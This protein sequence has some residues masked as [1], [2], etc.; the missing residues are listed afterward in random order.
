VQLLGQ[1][2]EMA[3]VGG[4]RSLWAVGHLYGP[5]A[6]TTLNRGAIWRFTP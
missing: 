5:G 6:G 3:L 1:V 4:T 2:D